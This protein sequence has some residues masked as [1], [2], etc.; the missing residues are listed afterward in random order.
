MMFMLGKYILNLCT[1]WISTKA[2]KIDLKH[3][4]TGHQQHHQAE[5]DFPLD[6]KLDDIPAR[7]LAQ[8]Q[9]IF[10]EPAPKQGPSTN[11]C[12]TVYPNF[13]LA[14]KS[15]VIDQILL[16]DWTL[17]AAVT[18]PGARTTCYNVNVWQ[19]CLRLRSPL[20]A[21]LVADRPG[22]WLSFSC[23]G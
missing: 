7:Q 3:S 15:R 8:P 14:V 13:V 10:Q 5:Q 20:S 22:W 21:W 6:S 2:C 17:A 4:Q 18:W 11:T 19:S 16:H 23:R 1:T 12:Q 9:G